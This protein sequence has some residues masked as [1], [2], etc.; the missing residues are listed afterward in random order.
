MEA[1]AMSSSKYVQE[2][3]KNDKR[4]LAEREQKLPTQCSMPLPASYRPELDISPELDVADANYYQSVIGILRWAVELGRVD[5]TTEVS[6]LSSHLALP[7]E[8]YL[9]GAFHVFAYTLK[10][11]TMPEWF[12]IRHIL[13][14]TRAP[15]RHMTGRIYFY[16]DVK[17]VIPPNAPDP[18]G[19]EVVIRCFVD[20]YHAGDKLS[21]RSR[22]GFIIFVNGAP[23]VWYSKQHATIKT[24]TFGSEFVA[25]KVATDTI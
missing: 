18:L 3:I 8:G 4:W 25:A 10:R 17:E 2:A 7:R 12:L 11:N 6:M 5:I 13:S 9:V 22:T 16:G 23:I 15:S 14:L 1:W 19:K 20:A 24:N 21:R